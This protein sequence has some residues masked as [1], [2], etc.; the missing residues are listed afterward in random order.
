MPVFDR[1]AFVGSGLIGA[2][3]A[4]TCVAHDVRTV[5]YTRRDVEGVQKRMDDTLNFFTENGLMAQEQRRLA[6]KMYRITTSVKDAVQDMPFVQES[7][8]EKIELK[9]NK[10]N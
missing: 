3:L 9:R 7:G 2:G 5:L 10:I 1:V 4:A 8:P 6:D